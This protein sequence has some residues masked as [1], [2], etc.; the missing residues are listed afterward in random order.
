MAHAAANTPKPSLWKFGGL[1]T[2]DLGKKVWKEFGD[3]EVTTRAASLAYYFLLAVFPALLFLLSMLGYFASVGTHVRE[4]LFNVLARALPASAGELVSKTINEVVKANGSG[5]AIF[6]VLGALWAASS[7]VGAIMQSLNAAYDVQETRPWWKKP[8]ISVGLTIALTVFIIAPM[9]LV[10]Y[11]AE[12]AQLIANHVGFGSIFVTAWRI[13]QWPIALAFMFFAFALVYY[14]APNV[15]DPE[16]HWITPGSGLGVFVWLAASFGLRIYLHFFNSYSRSYGSLGAVI[17]LLL[18]LYL[19][20]IAIMLGGELNSV[21]AH[22]DA[23]VESGEKPKK[24][25]E[26]HPKMAA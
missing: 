4:T 25:D 20:G 12:L 9:V 10:L 15:K 8:L 24:L 1:K 23:V 6:G 19:T 7:G 21:I 18:W 3:D 14:F 2:V 17:I 11:G 13:A 26:K 22:E 5:K 16:W